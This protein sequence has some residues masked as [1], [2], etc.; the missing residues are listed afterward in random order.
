MAEAAAARTTISSLKAHQVFQAAAAARHDQQVGARHGALLGQPLKPAMAAATSPAAFSPCTATGQTSTWRG[1]RSARRCRMSRITAPDG[2]VTTPI[3]SGRNGSSR[4]RVE[5]EQAFGA[6]FL[7]RSSSSLSSAPSPAQFEPVD[8]DLVARGAGVGRER[9]CP[10]T[11]CSVG[12]S[13][14]SPG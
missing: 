10:A 8:D 4:L 9:H 11:L 13:R 2:E 6:S 14:L 1:K 7:R 5:I 3:T 12:H